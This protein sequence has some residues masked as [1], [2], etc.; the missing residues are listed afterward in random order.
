[1][2]FFT[3][4]KAVTKNWIR[5][6]SGLFFSIMFPILLLLVFGAIFSGFGGSSTYSIYIQNLDVDSQGHAT[7]LS[8]AFITA[9]N[10]TNTFSMKGIP[11]DANATDY[12]T[13]CSWT[14]RWNH[15][16]PRYF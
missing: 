9:L 13:G 7:E 14:V 6:R 10:S 4:L 5:S 8:S 3:V 16:Y 1:M 11:V 12:V 2:K 15:A